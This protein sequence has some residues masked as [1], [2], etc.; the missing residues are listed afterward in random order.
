M[1]AGPAAEDAVR[2]ARKMP[3]LR[4]GLHLVVIEGPSV[5]PQAAIPALVD[6]KRQF[7]SDQLRLGLR[8]FFLPHVRRQLAA[9]IRAQ[10]GAFAAT[11]LPTQGWCVFCGLCVKGRLSSRRIRIRRGRHSCISIPAMTML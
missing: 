8:Y 9:E 10:F 1:V 5:L 11:G 2:R 6:R 7:P 4:V 3:N